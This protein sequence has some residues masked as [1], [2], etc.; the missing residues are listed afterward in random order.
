MRCD[1]LTGYTYDF[2]VYAGKDETGGVGTLGERVIKKLALTIKDKD[3][4]LKIDRFFTS[5]Y[6]MDSLEFTPV[7][8]CQNT[9]KNFPGVQRKLKKREAEFKSNKN[10]TLA[11]TWHD[12]KEMSL[13]SNCHTN[14]SVQIQKKQKD[15]SK[16]DISCPEVISFYRQKM[17]GVDLADQIAGLYDLDRKFLKWWK[18]VIYRTLMISAINSWVIYKE[19]KRHPK[20]HFWTSFV[21]YLKVSL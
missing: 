6:L 19:I 14:T 20:I 21:T 7:E 11:V 17:G 1:S 15:G 18:K 2:N 4:T 12:T 3:V 13:L 9:R 16:I 5:V 8:T 10:G